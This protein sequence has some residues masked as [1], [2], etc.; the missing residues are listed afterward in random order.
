MFK[1]SEKTQD[2]KAESLKY[3]V[4]RR[5]HAERKAAIQAKIE[6]FQANGGAEEEEEEEEEDD[7]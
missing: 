4:H 1:P 2:W 7:E 3:K 6:A 5:T